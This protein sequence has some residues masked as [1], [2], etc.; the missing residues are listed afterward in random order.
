MRIS[1]VR[2][3]LYLKE[4]SQTL[5]GHFTAQVGSSRLSGN[6]PWH[7]IQ[8][9]PRFWSVNASTPKIKLQSDSS[10]PFLS[11]IKIQMRMCFPPMWASLLVQLQKSKSQDVCSNNQWGTRCVN[12]W[13][14]LCCLPQLAVS[15]SPSVRWP[16]TQR[17]DVGLSTN[18]TATPSLLF[19]INLV[20]S[21]NIL[22][23]WEFIQSLIRRNFP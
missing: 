13:L 10:C 21:I 14:V 5:C 23:N 1:G 15:P 2:A 6:I 12:L 20:F 3:K 19:S 4:D 22:F 18:Q 8:F 9:S 11:C 7:L 17:D 16:F